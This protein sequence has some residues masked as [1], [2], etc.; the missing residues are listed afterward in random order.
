MLE[1]FCDSV[2][3]E[4]SFCYLKGRLNCG[5]GKSKSWWDKIWRIF[6]VSF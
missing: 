4:N 3:L 2:E 1:I 6:R 5:G